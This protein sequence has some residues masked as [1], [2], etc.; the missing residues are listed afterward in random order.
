MNVLKKTTFKGPCVPKSRQFHNLNLLK[1]MN[2][3]FNMILVPLIKFF[4]QKFMWDKEQLV[5]FSKT[6]DCRC[7]KAKEVFY[8]SRITVVLLST[9]EC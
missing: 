9:E 2:L 5:V 1:K 3:I 8:Q 4:L 7:V 6:K